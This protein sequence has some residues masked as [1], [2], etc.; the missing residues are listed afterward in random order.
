MLLT[1]N[2]TILTDQVK[3]TS[4]IIPDQ[5]QGPVLENGI[6][7]NHATQ[8]LLAEKFINV[9]FLVPFPKFEPDLRAELGAYME[10]LGKLW[11][12]LTWLC[13][14]DYSTNFQKN[15]ST[16]DVDWLLH[17]VK[18]EVTLAE[19]E[20]EVLRIYTSSFLNYE[21]TAAQN[22]HRPP[23]AAPLAMMALASVGL[24]GSGIALGGGSRGNEGI[25][26]SC[27]DKSKS[28][29]ENIQKL[30]DFTEALTDVSKLRNEVNDKFFMV[31]VRTCCN[32]IRS[33]GNA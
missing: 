8:I 19:Q 3:W 4:D 7:F 13:H 32:Q 29:A 11:A 23:R 15:D 26:G 33:K 21:A 20:L 14:L 28:N 25:F 16:F 22:I 30:A 2:A 27:H 12:S 17:Q 1:C 9:D 5:A 31:N 18:N 24:Y 10:K 6:I